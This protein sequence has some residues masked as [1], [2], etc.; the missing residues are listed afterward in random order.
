M[1]KE[2][3]VFLS[4]FIFYSLFINWYGW[5]EQ[6]HFVLVKAIGEEN[7]FE[8]DSFYNTT[9][10]RA[11]FNGHYYSDKDPGLAII[12][13][14]IYIFWSRLYQFLPSKLKEEYSFNPNIFYEDISGKEKIYWYVNLGLLDYYSMI[15]L[16]IF[17]STIFSALTVVLVFKVSSMFLKSE[18]WKASV[19]LTYGLA[20]LQFPYSLHFMNHATSTFFAFLSFYTLLSHT[21]FRKM[22][23]GGI[24]L[25]FATT[26][27]HS[28]LLLALPLLLFSIFKKRQFLPIFFGFMLGALPLLLYNFVNFKNPFVFASTYVDRNIFIRAYE[29]SQTP[30]VKVKK[31]SLFDLNFL[32][33]LH[34]ESK[35]N[36]FVVLRLLFYPYRGLFFYHSV[37]LLSIPGLILMSKKYKLESIF[38]FSLLLL[39][40]IFVSMRRIW[41]GGY[42]FGERYFL[43]ITPFLFIPL[44]YL[45]SKNHAKKLFLFLAVLSIIVNI[46]GLGFAEDDAYD[47]KTMDMRGDWFTEQNSF[48]IL[49]NP[50]LEHYI[51]QFFKYGPRSRILEEV[52]NGYIYEVDIR[53]TPM[54]CGFKCNRPYIHIPFLPLLFFIFPLLFLSK[55]LLKDR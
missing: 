43:P 39:F 51:P 35:P 18:R 44:I 37:L 48:K 40:P 31:L 16:T 2:F 4:F 54:P 47:W 50:L 9:G 5:N 32:E 26:I 19:A 11:V 3:K 6:S 12:S 1:K 53:L 22:L 55:E 13:Q 14:P 10:D 41:W 33:K 34:F 17:S 7:R 29:I 24:A 30:S 46:L 36:L 42:C 45:L 25:G 27:D 21:T 38:I 23:L 15:F 28:I 8:I 49:S 52:L 20:T